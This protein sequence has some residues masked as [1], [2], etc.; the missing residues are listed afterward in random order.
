MGNELKGLPGHS[1][2]YFGDTRAHWWH[3]D[4]LQMA[5]RRW[6]LA[7]SPTVLDVGCGVGH[8]GR[9]LARAMP[10]GTSFVGLDR[11]PAWIEE[12]TRRAAVAGL[13]ERFSYRVGTAEALPFEDG[14]F[15]VVTCQTLLIHVPDPGRVL[16][17]LVRVTRPG[18]LVI[19]AEPSNAAGFLVE[20]V[21]LGDPPETAA[22]L[23]S[24][25]LTCVR[26]KK[27]LG[28]G[29]NL[30]GETLPLLLHRAGLSGVEVRQNDRCGSMLPP[31][32]SPFE[33][34]E[35]EEAIDA[36][37]REIGPWDQATT[38]RYF[39][40]GG[41]SEAAFRE[42]WTAAQAHRCRVADGVRAGTYSCAGGG[43]F[44][45]GWGWRLNGPTA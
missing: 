5:A 9:A 1:A 19:A 23:V 16:A 26:G 28:E 17:E 42:R 45:L 2:E 34:A 20:S 8:W 33:R 21:A 10:Q 38:R 41:G 44:Y 31:Y 32:D 15:D 12:A 11:E 39:L 27:V 40:A 36:V 7:G 13:S 22:S 43:L 24:F 14:A 25:H 18:G 4:Y 35:V 6:R 3:D 30:I 37:D 29:D